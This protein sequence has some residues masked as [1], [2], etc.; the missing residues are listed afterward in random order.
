M[1]DYTS[2][3]PKP[4]DRI[5]LSLILF[6][7][8][9]IIGVLLYNTLLGF[10]ILPF[11][12]IPCEKKY[13]EIKKNKRKNRL[14]NEF[15]DVLYSLSASFAA[16]EHMTYAMEKSIKP[17]REI[18]GEN[19]EMAEELSEMTNRIRGAGDEEID[20]W[21]DFGKRSGI[22]DIID[23]AE[24]FASCRDAGGNL[25]RTVDRAT[26][27]LT[28]KIAVENEIRIMASQ[29]VLEGRLVGIMP[30]VMI[31]F[32]RLTS[33]SYMNVMYESIQGRI[34]MTFSL[35]ITIAAFYITERVTKID[36]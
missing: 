12:Y 14:R 7:T 6:A 15:K 18:H 29:K 32:L 35:L 10:V 26:E 2:Y 13:C 17:V 22:E 36:I 19:S 1:T 4:K 11:V 24:V 3:R 30:F 23:F 9:E 31:V 5:V 25:V 8:L 28:E 34:M 21:L 27:V 20:L 33:P 16:G